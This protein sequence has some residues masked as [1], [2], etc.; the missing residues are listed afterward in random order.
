MMVLCFHIIEKHAKVFANKIMGY[1]RF[2]SQY[3]QGG[4]GAEGG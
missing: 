1:L 2:A 4:T 3:Q